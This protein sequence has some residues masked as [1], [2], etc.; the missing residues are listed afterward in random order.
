MAAIAKADE[1]LAETEMRVLKRT[2]DLLGLTSADIAAQG[3]G[4]SR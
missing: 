2:L 1:Q 3:Q 4:G